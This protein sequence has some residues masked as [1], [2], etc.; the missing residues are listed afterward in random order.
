[1][2][3]GDPPCLLSKA[4]LG[5]GDVLN[6]EERKIGEVSGAATVEVL[7]HRSAAMVLD[8]AEMFGNVALERS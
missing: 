7:A 6:R 2:E 3:S 5:A 1:M 8:V 4:S